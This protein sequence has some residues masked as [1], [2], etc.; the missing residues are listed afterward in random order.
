[1]KGGGGDRMMI[2]EVNNDSTVYSTRSK[3]A[4]HIFTGVA[5]YLQTS[6]SYA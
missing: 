4:I 6:V 5:Y 1:M 3:T 2:G